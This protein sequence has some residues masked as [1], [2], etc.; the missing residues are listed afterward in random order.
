[1]H[2]TLWS[3]IVS[4]SSWR[5]HFTTNWMKK[6]FEIKDYPVMLLLQVVRLWDFNHLLSS[7]IRVK[8][9]L[10]TLVIWRLNQGSLLTFIISFSTLGWG[11]IF[12]R[13]RFDCLHCFFC[14]WQRI[15]YYWLLCMLIYQLDGQFLYVIICFLLAYSFD[16][17]S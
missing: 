14:K 15:S 11:V 2:F 6:M 5:S 3:F 9:W 8:F 13:L 1:M 4:R 17:V 10:L 12:E 16:V 7:F